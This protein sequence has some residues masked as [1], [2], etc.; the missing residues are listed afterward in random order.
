MKRLSILFLTFLSWGIGTVNAQQWYRLTN[1][2]NPLSSDTNYWYVYP[3]SPYIVS[4]GVIF[5]GVSWGCNIF[6]CGGTNIIE[7]TD[8]LDTCKDTYQEGSQLGAYMFLDVTSKNDSTFCFM[9]PYTNFSLNYTSNTFSN[10]STVNNYTNT[11]ISTQLCFSNNYIYAV[12]S[13]QSNTADTLRTYRIPIS[14]LNA[15]EYST[16]S[17]ISPSHLIF[18][19]DSVG[20]LLC[21]YANNSAKSVLATT[22]DSG[23]TWKDSFLDSTHTITGFSFP[24]P[25]VGYLIENN[26][27]I[28]KTTNG[29]TTWVQLTSPTT[30][31]LNCVSFSNPLS[32]YVAGNKGILYKT[33]NGGI[34]WTTEISNDTSA[35]TSLYTFDTVAYFIDYY[36]NIYKNESPLSIATLTTPLLKVNVFPNPST[37]L[38]TIQSTSVNVNARVEIYNMLGETIYTQTLR[39][40]QGDNT[41]DLRNKANGIYLYR[42]LTETGGLISTGKLIIQK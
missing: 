25:A 28:L 12:N 38:F 7:S 26:G 41:I 6:H 18:T 34:S 20:Y 36:S 24:T 4:N 37:G 31:Q 29:G 15:T 8:D 23:K 3:I 16:F 2:K 30:I 42:I 11:Y 14:T 13:N 40:A 39:Q 1:Y 33:S 22:T 19:N 32:G 10:V 5:Y 35:I 27:N 21:K 17:Y 9:N